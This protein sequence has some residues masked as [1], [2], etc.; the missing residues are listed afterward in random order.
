M[1]F[2]DIKNKVISCVKAGKAQSTPRADKNEKNLFLTGDVDA[3]T[4]VSM[5]EKTRGT[6]HETMPHSSIDGV[7]VNI[8]KPLIGDEQWYIKFYIIDPDCI[9]I[10]VH[11]SKKIVR[12]R[13]V[14]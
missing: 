4:L 14:K 11:F 12:K 8:F 10:S 2:D 1:G 5:L 13:K 7:E 3:E 6:Q 9:F